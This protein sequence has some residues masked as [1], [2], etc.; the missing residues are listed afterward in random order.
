MAKATGISVGKV[1]SISESQNYVAPYSNQMVKS[2]M[3][4]DGGNQ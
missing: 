1:M 2:N 3:M 4:A